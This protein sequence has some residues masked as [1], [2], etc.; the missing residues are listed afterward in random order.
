MEIRIFASLNVVET[1]EL[2]PII[3]PQNP[4]Q[5]REFHLRG[6]I[7]IVIGALGFWYPLWYDSTIPPEIDSRIGS[8]FIV[9]APFTF[10]A[11]VWATFAFNSA[12][13]PHFISA[14]LLVMVWLPVLFVGVRIIGIIF[15]ILALQR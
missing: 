7:A 5:A 15:P 4:T 1:E 14:I 9:T 11:A 12:H 10:A 3:T 2:P 8:V 13:R 6:A